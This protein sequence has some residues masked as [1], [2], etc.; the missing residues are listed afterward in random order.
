MRFQRKKSERGVALIMV[1]GLMLTISFFVATAVT[2]SQYSEMESGT[3]SSFAYSAHLAEGAANRIYWYLLN[4]CKKHPSRQIVSNNLEDSEERYQADGRNHYL[5]NYNGRTLKIQVLDAVSGIDISEKTITREFTPLLKN[6]PE[7]SKERLYMEDLQNRI[8]DYID[9]DDLIRQDS[10]ERQDYLSLGIL[11]LPRNDRLQYREELFWIPGF[12]DFFSSD[13]SGRLTAI[14]L[15]APEGLKPLFGRS[16]FYSTLPSIIAQRCNLNPL[17]TAQLNKIFQN[18]DLQ[19][20]ELS[21][22]LSPSIYSKIKMYYSMKES[23]IY[24]LIIDTSSS[25]P[26]VRLAITFELKA[27]QIE[28]NYYEFMFF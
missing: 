15:I 14:R 28:Q 8:L 26:G 16:N 20:E 2:L 13:D 18:R 3:Y 23:G 22:L 6:Q 4:D 10:L 19:K 9:N 21:E 1:L 27:N 5:N 11:H 7:D 12:S 17:E 24:T 25:F